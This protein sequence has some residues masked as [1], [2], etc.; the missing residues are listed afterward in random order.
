[1]DKYQRILQTFKEN[2]DSMSSNEQDEYLKQ[3]GLKYQAKPV[4]SVSAA[5]RK[6]GFKARMSYPK[7]RMAALKSRKSP[8]NKYIRA[9]LN[10]L[11]TDTARAAVQPKKKVVACAQKKTQQ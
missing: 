9:A 11:A 1:M 5:R 2:F 7:I 4:P 8:S 6:R 3:M 10:Q